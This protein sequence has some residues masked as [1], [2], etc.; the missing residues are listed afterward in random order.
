MLSQTFEF[1]RIVDVQP[2]DEKVRKRKQSATDL[3]AH[4]DANDSQDI[5]LALLQGI[6]A[7]FDGSPFSQDSPAVV[8]LLKTIKDHDAAV[9]NDLKENAVELRAVAAIV[10]GELLTRKSES[11]YDDE[12]VVLA[13]A[14]R[15][16]LSLRPASKQKHIK[17]AL[18]K[19]LSA[20]DDLLRLAG[21]ERRKRGT[22][23]L[24]ELD[25]IKESAP[26]TDLWEVV[27]PKV[28]AALE[29]AV[30]QAAM[31][32]EEIET[33]W[34]L[35]AAYSETERKPLGDL[36]PFAAAFCSGVELAKRALLPP[37]LSSA[38][39]VKRAVDSGRKAAS[40]AATAL[41][42]TLTDWSQ[43][44]MDALL[45]ADGSQDAVVSQFP[46]LLP[47]S[48]ACRRLRECPDTPKLGKEFTAGTGMPVDASHPPADWGAQVFREKVL[49]RV[50]HDGLGRA[51]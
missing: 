16:A 51:E 32:R 44:M 23:A 48:Y 20:A 30:D 15:S 22:L 14:L 18:D 42:D 36:S 19:L 24:R 17:W 39:M 33:L 46:A 3:L 35:F 40:L 26:E 8:L 4:F 29:E 13:L 50:L 5:M 25:K 43:S 2:S 38:A 1:L 31:D 34:W 41:G 6:V 37:S 45:P 10:I 9:P 12:A 28:K 27:V 11:A 47:V 21:S 49:L 7:A